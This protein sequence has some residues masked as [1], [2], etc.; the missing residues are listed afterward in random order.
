M[1]DSCLVGDFS[2]LTG[3]KYDYAYVN[4]DNLNNYINWSKKNILGN[5]DNINVLT[6]MILEELSYLI[7]T[8]I[9]DI[10]I[11]QSKGV[12]FTD[13]VVEELRADPLPYR[14]IEDEEFIDTV[15]DQDSE[16]NPFSENV[17]ERISPSFVKSQGQIQWQDSSGSLHPL[18]IA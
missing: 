12:F 4:Y 10:E 13:L 7:S 15:L 9:N 8:Q 3:Q 6:D 17:F 1:Q 14:Y 11:V 5:Q 2:I 18:P 16:R